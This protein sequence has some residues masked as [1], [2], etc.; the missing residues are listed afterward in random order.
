MVVGLISKTV[1]LELGDCSSQS[2]KKN[3][4]GSLKTTAIDIISAGASP[5]HNEIPKLKQVGSIASASRSRSNST[6]VMK[7]GLI[8]VLTN[9]IAFESFIQ[10]CAFECSVENVLFLIEIVQ[11]K[12][13]LQKYNVPEK[14]DM[15][16]PRKME[17][18]MQNMKNTSKQT[19]AVRCVIYIYI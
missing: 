9:E 5:R 4:L 19:S 17:S 3:A 11:Y 10:H 15:D 13:I 14:L 7:I 6:N 1:K 16:W 12:A 2:S 18:N 8:D